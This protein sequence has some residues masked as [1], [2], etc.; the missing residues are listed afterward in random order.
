MAR[1]SARSLDDSKA[2]VLD[3]AARIAVSRQDVV[4][5]SLSL[6]AAAGYEAT[7]CGSDITNSS[8]ASLTLPGSIGIAYDVHVGGATLSPFVSGTGARYDRRTYLD[9]DRLPTVRGWDAQYTRGVSL[10]VKDAIVAA[11]SIRGEKGAAARHRWTLSAG[12]SF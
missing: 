9:D 4:T 10:R 1:A 8:R 5:P 2:G 11:S 12:I 7:A 3:V 6:S